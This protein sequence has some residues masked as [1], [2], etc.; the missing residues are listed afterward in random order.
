MFSVQ[1]ETP[2]R[3]WEV[4]CLFLKTGVSFSTWV[5]WSS[6]PSSVPVGWM[7]WAKFGS[8][9]QLWNLSHSV[10]REIFISSLHMVMYLIWDI[11]FHKMEIKDFQNG[12][13]SLAWCSTGGPILLW[14]FILLFLLAK[15]LSSTQPSS[16]SASPHPGP[17]LQFYPHAPQL[18]LV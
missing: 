2:Y 11:I 8:A 7:A 17:P 13:C 10:Q 6:I 16:C 3:L 9:F 1:K 12:I 4:H 15:N 18:T 5:L 14:W